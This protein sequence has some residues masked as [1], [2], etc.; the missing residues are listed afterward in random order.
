MNRV[1]LFA[2]FASILNMNVYAQLSAVSIRGQV[3]DKTQTPVAF[4]NVVVAQNGM[5]T[6]TDMMGNF[7]LSGLSQGD[8]AITVSAVG[9]EVYNEVVIIQNGETVNLKIIL[10]DVRYSMPQIEVMGVRNRALQRLPGSAALI[11]KR[12]LDLIAPVSGNEVFRR[13]TGLHV[14]D[15]E[16]AGLRTNIGIRGLDPDRSRTVLVL[17]DGIPVALN[18]YGEPE[19]YYTPAMD[20][21]AGVEVVKGAGQIA[22]GPRTI[23]GVINYITADPPAE[24]E[25]NVKLQGG[26]GGY[27]SGLMSYGNTYGN[28]GVQVSYLRK[29]A[30]DIAGTSFRLN[31]L[32]AKFRFE[33]S[34]KSSLGLKLGL[35]NETS[36]STYIG[37]T[38]TMFDA[39]GQDFVRMAPDDRL[40]V[41]RNSLSATHRVRF[42]ANTELR[43]SAYGYL[44][45][46]DWRRQDFNYTGTANNHT[47]VVWGDTSVAGGAIF[48]R[49]SNGHRNRS[50]AVAGID[51]R[52]VHKYELGVKNEVQVGARL[53]Y[54]NALEQRINGTRPDSESGALVEDESRTGNAQSAFIENKT[55]ITEALV[56]TAGLRYENYDYEREIFRNRFDG[57][58]KD[59][60]VVAG[61]SV[62]QLIPG[63]GINYSVNEKVQLFA[64]VHRGFAPPRLKDAITAQGVAYQLDAELSWN[65]EVGTRA[66]LYKGVQMELTGFVLDFSNQII[67]VSESSGGTGA[68]EVNGGSTM[69]RGVELGLIVGFGQIFDAPFRL[70]LDVNATAI[71]AYFNSDRFLG[72]DDDRTNI[73]GNRTPYA[74]ELLLSSAL[75]FETKSGFGLRLTGTYV[76]EQFADELN[77]VN[78]TPDGLSGLIPSYFLLDGTTRYTVSKWKTTF[79]LSCKNMLDERY[80]ASRRPQGIRVGLPRFITAGVAVQF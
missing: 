54:E 46:R 53:Q 4:A 78:P 14:V 39:G 71:D 10:T 28:T 27:F 19:M 41:N 29:Q 60:N 34:E 51:S 5:G 18:P 64:G 47:G 22:Y 69:H 72:A 52:L 61:N 24:E 13:I 45:S 37:M 35:Y 42:N 7:T 3:I 15:E 59:T 76:S 30:D 55:W 1:F 63:V 20:R 43:T 48:M 2:L 6:A 57:V 77:T 67:P 40:D 44:T 80:M 11:D 8:Y 36:N 66:N 62:S 16:G 17:E 49:S 68:G 65:Y 58:V 33:L 38:Q 73:Q 26:Q 25:V 56:L 32:T 70:D 23:G 21:M 9:Y 75:T 31:D 74:P 12:E 79:S 50:F